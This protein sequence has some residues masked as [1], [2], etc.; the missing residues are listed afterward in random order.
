MIS[1]TGCLITA[2]FLARY[3]LRVNRGLRGVF[4]GLIAAALAGVVMTFSSSV[5]VARLLALTMLTGVGWMV[6]SLRAKA[7]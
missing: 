6:W 7:S 4:V 1:A 3:H 5:F 2:A